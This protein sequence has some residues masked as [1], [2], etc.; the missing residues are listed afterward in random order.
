[1]DLDG[2]VALVTGASSGIGA[3]TARSLADAG[4]R[5]GLAARRED[6]LQAISSEVPTDAVSIETD[7]RN[8]EQIPEMVDEVESEFDTIDVLVNNA[9]VVRPNPVA[10]A[11]PAD[12]RTQVQVNLLAVMETTR[13]GVRTMA[14]S[15]GGHVVIVS[16]MTSRTPPPGLGAYAATKSGV[17]SF[18]QALRKEMATNGIRVTTI[19]PGGTA[20]EMGEQMGLDGEMLQPEDVSEAILFALNRPDHV[21]IRELEITPTRREAG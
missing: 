7:L 9:G 15:N 18:S 6:R 14:R 12:V 10:S 21:S 16:S 4:C 19:I 5:L 20:S 2:A 1:M 13:L 17:N 11:P 3:A 8:P